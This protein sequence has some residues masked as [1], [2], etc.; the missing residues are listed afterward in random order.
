MV[1]LFSKKKKIQQNPD[2]E[3]ILAYFQ[4]NTEDEVVQRIANPNYPSSEDIL[5]KMTEDYSIYDKANK[6]GKLSAKLGQQEP[7]RQD[8][9]RIFSFYLNMLQSAM[10]EQII[11]K[12]AHTYYEQNI[13]PA[14]I[15][16]E[17]YLLRAASKTELEL[18]SKVIITGMKKF[19]SGKD[20]YS[21]N[22]R[23]DDSLYEEK[24]RK[25]KQEKMYKRLEYL[26][27][28]IGEEIKQ[29]GKPIY[30]AAPWNHNSYRK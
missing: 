10:A 12:E 24:N 25:T 13:L 2:L 5:R 27:E 18:M 28:K 1:N 20:L 22:I 17:D 21:R 14:L 9:S 26:S 3:Q 4:A 19:G 23:D 30:I 29:R 11:Q 16:L 7:Q 6:E 15:T 8:V